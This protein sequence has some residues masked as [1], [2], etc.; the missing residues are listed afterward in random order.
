MHL[1]LGVLLEVEL[2]LELVEL[3]PKLPLIVLYVRSVALERLNLAHLF[4][5]FCLYSRQICVKLSQFLFQSL[6]FFRLFSC[7]VPLQ[8]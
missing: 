5:L 4:A 7:V 8:L 6:S 1:L 3:S 2:L